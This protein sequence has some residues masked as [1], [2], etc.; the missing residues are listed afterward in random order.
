MG[1]KSREK[2]DRRQRGEARFGSFWWRRL[3]ASHDVHAGRLWGGDRFEAWAAVELRNMNRLDVGLCWW[4]ETHLAL[5]V[6]WG[7]PG[8][9]PVWTVGLGVVL[10]RR[11]ADWLGRHQVGS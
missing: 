1:R 2:A 8:S 3:T 5:D 7:H 10:P 11:V 9:D 6:S 4:S